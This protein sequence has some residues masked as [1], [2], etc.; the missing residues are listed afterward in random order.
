MNLLCTKKSVFHLKNGRIKNTILPKAKRNHIKA[1]RFRVLFMAFALM[2]QCSLAFGQTLLHNFEFNNNLSD[3]KPTGVT[4]TATSG[5]DSSSFGT[6]PN[7]WTWTEATR[8][9]GGL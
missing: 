2:V 4:L 9:G 6:S 5:L 7:S 3:T 8:P 1:V